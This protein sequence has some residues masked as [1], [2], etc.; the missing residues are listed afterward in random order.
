[1]ENQS[2]GGLGMLPVLLN[3]VKLSAPGY[4]SQCFSAAAVFS[5]DL[6]TEDSGEGPGSR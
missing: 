1:M 3:H 5:E 4:W 6:T 2:P